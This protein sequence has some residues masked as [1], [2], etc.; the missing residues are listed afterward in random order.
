MLLDE[1]KQLKDW[2][3]LK[4]PQLLERAQSFADWYC[5]SCIDTSEKLKLGEL[6]IELWQKARNDLRVFA[7]LLQHSS[8][9]LGWEL[10]AL[11]IWA[12]AELGTRY[13]EEIMSFARWL[14]WY[15]RL[16]LQDEWDVAFAVCA[17]DYV[18]K[19]FLAS[20]AINLLRC[21]N[22]LFP[23]SSRVQAAE[24]LAARHGA[25]TTDVF[26]SALEQLSW[27]PKGKQSE[28]LRREARIGRNPA[29]TGRN[30]EY[31]HEIAE[32]DLPLP[33]DEPSPL[34]LAP[35]N[36]PDPL[37]VVANKD[38]VN[39]LLEKACRD[40]MDRDIV[41]LLLQ[42]LSLK[43]VADL[44][45]TSHDLVRQRWSRL[46]RRALKIFSETA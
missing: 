37:E 3:N 26:A 14:N 44:L 11:I 35:S 32:S 25:T 28:P 15:S 33:E 30:D 46:R 38:T 7:Q 13:R 23:P 2:R 29:G 4:N 20:E 1:L 40:R 8:S 45:G 16:R 22:P 27:E 19:M 42:D 21:A 36:E 39:R 31:E 18:L 9:L 5:S 34:E 43:D 6:N 17:Y 24:L 41:N 12:G 10:I